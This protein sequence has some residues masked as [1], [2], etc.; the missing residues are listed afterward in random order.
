V[1]TALLILLIAQGLLTAQSGPET[2]GNLNAAFTLER[3]AAAYYSALDYH[4]VIETKVVSTLGDSS[5][6]KYRYE[7]AGSRPQF[8]FTDEMVLSPRRY[9]V[10][11]GTDGSSVWGYSPSSKVYVQDSAQAEATGLLH[12]LTWQHFRFFTRFKELNTFGKSAVIE[13]R[14]MLRIQGE[15]NRVPCIRIRLSVP[16]ADWTEQLWIEESRALVRKSVLQKKEVMETITTTTLWRSIDLTAPASAQ[17]LFS[18]PANAKRTNQLT[19][20]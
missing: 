1:T 2:S 19:V 12:D 3:A 10:R 6:T 13:G 15:P 17:F 7:I 4:A 20:P 11:L 18:P 14:D 5:E 8:L 9:Q 16:G